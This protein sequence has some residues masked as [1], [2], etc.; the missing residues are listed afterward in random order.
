MNYDKF[1][2]K[3]IIYPV[4]N[5]MLGIGTLGSARI[6]PV[7]SLTQCFAAPMQRTTLSYTL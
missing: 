2:G 1:F 5:T 4:L 7:N 6:P 3:S